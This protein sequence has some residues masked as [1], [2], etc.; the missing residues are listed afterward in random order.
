MTDKSH[1]GESRFTPLTEFKLRS[2][3][4]IEKARTASDVLGVFRLA[5]T[6]LFPSV[7][8]G[9]RRNHE[10]R[11]THR[12]ATRRTLSGRA[13]RGRHGRSIDRT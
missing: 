10:S 6:S 8:I 2:R 13:N 7:T 3:D 11:A 5:M 12:A 9:I 4:D 1:E